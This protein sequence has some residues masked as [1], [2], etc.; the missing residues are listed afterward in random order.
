[1]ILARIILL[2]DGN[3]HSIIR[4]RWVTK[5]F[6]AG[7]VLSFLAQS[8]GGGLLAVAKT[9]SDVKMGENVIIAGLF[10]QVIVF[11][12]FVIVSGIFNIRIRKVPTEASRSASIPWQRHLYNLYGASALIM[13]RSVFR[14]IE[15]IMGNDGV[16]LQHEYYLYIFD[17]V[18][19]FLVTAQ[20]IVYHPS[21]IISSGMFKHN[22]NAESIDSG[23]PLETRENRAFFSKA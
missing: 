23:Y 16:L 22:K 5:I 8:S 10:I 13:I 4:V 20:F 11:G 12:F 18:L 19:M 6:V 17:A 1:M 15:Y 2:T 14:V 3:Q 9:A 21:D 7:D